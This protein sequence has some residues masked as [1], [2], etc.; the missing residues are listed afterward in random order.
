MESNYLSL[1]DI[2][3]AAI[4]NAQLNN[5][6]AAI[7]TL[8][9]GMI[10]FPDAEQLPFLLGAMYVELSDTNSALVNYEKSILIN[11]NFYIAEFQL[12]MLYSCVSQPEKARLHWLSI[13]NKL[14]SQPTCYLKLF[15]DGLIALCDFRI[16]DAM[17][18]LEEGLLQNKENIAL[19]GDIQTVLKLLAEDKAIKVDLEQNE[20]ISDLDSKNSTSSHLLLKLY[21]Q[22]K[23]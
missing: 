4:K 21:N 17:L 13:S 2:I 7:E 12:A 20:L 3:L 8:K 9:R 11:P 14:I 19:N 18:L 1:N 15:A 10:L 23:H 16:E 22:S 5:Y 6:L